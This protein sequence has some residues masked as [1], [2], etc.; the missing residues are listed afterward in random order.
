M[1][2]SVPVSPVD[3]AA[4][5]AHVAAAHDK[6]AALCDG[7]ERWRMS[8]PAEPERDAD[9]VISRAL[10]HAD[11]L[12]AEVK[13]LRERTHDEALIRRAIADPGQFLPRGDNY[14]EPITSWSARAVVAALDGTS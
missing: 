2:V 4:I 10:A 8:I 7:R 13:G 1:V 5:E 6:V 14:A 9:L 11:S 12:V 3:L